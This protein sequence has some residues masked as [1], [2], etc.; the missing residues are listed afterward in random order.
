M[1]VDEFPS[2]NYRP[3]TRRQPPAPSTARSSSSLMPTEA[4]RPPARP[5]HKSVQHS[6]H[7]TKYPDHETQR[8]RRLTSVGHVSG[9]PI[10]LDLTDSSVL[11][12]ARRRFS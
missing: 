10:R 11:P 3:S 9:K 5:R 1:S 12:G 4:T 8:A 7:S 6:Y 2:A